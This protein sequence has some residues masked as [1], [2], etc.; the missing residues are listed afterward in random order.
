MLNVSGRLEESTFALS[1][2]TLASFNPKLSP[3]QGAASKALC[4]CFRG[5]LKT[6]F[7][8]VKKSGISANGTR[9]HNAAPDKRDVA[10]IEH[11]IKYYDWTKPRCGSAA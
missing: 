2:I 6:P 8:K 5:F 7:I 3:A 9:H 11:R 4:N 10:R 1:K